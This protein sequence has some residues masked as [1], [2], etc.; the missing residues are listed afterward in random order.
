MQRLWDGACGI[1]LCCQPQIDD[2]SSKAP[3]SP[4]SASCSGHSRRLPVETDQA[5]AG[6][7][8]LGSRARELGFLPHC[9]SQ[10]SCRFPR[11]VCPLPASLSLKWLVHPR[12]SI[13]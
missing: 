9:S 6:N 11:R 3:L 7:A 2:P 5:V 1:L 10:A 8:S 12:T 4:G 13:S